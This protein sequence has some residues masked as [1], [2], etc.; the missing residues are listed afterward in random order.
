MRVHR[1]LRV[2]VAEMASALVLALAL[3][4]F[5][6]QLSTPEP[7]DGSTAQAVQPIEAQVTAIHT[8]ASSIPDGD[9]VGDLGLP[10]QD[11]GVP[12]WSGWANLDTKRVTARSTHEAVR[13]VASRIPDG[14]AIGI[15]NTAEAP[16]LLRLEVR[17]PAGRYTIDRLVY[18]PGHVHLER[19][20]S[21]APDGGGFIRKPGYLA[22]KS[23]AVYRF[24]NHA[25]RASATYM[26]AAQQARAYASVSSRNSARLMAAL[27]ECPWML[28]QAARLIARKNPG[29][30]LRPIHRALLGIRH[31]QAVCGNMTAPGEAAA[32]LRSRIATELD[33]L[34]ASL[35]ECSVAALG[36]VPSADVEAGEGRTRIRLG[37][38]NS[39]SQSISAVKLWLTGPRGC[40]VEPSL[41]AV[42]DTLRPGQTV[43]AEFT[44]KTPGASADTQASARRA[45]GDRTDGDLCG[46]LSYFRDQAPAHVRIAVR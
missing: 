33:A 22:P 39:G 41:Q 26:R 5:V 6:R 20:Q 13:A 27:R 32:R 16:A 3:S 14:L 40:V 44:A 19:L 35:G 42:F 9:A 18:G 30:A 28:T 43:T 10:P 12:Q 24:V 34:E 37:V 23:G 15:G 8:T 36:L 25:S 11:D 7:E 38:R 29:E 21:S 1:N 4:A 31:A 46:H 17:L 2:G 45:P